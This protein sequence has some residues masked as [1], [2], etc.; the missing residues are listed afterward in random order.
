MQGTSRHRA[1]AV[2]LRSGSA[3]GALGLA[4]AGL[5]LVAW[6]TLHLGAIFLWDW[7]RDPPALAVL[8]ILAQA[9]LSTGLFIVAHDAMHGS[10]VPGRPRLNDAI[11]RLALMV[12]AGLD[13]D[14]L[15]PAHFAHHRAPGTE[16][17]P[18]FHPGRPRAFWPWLAR[19][20]L[21]YYTHAQL[22]RI[23]LVA[24]L[25]IF[26]GGASLANIAAFWAVPALLAMLQL[27]AFGTFLPHRRSEHPFADWHHA[28]SNG[29]G[30]FAALLT[31][32][33]FG[34]YHHEHHLYPHV[35]WWALPST[36]SEGMP[37]ARR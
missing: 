34:A 7:N 24:C 1:R 2:P 27:F 18:D 8:V 13:Y 11:G 23:T 26:A 32:F 33:N 5:L 16:A 6:L 22:L 36:R 37:K 14:R 31:C 17:D 30:R 4:L 20:F 28:R 3:T 25:Y 10:L 12:Y 9:W 19:F 35:P 29:M 21:G 15:R